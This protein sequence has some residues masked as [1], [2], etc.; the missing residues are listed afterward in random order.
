[1]Q[2]FL[3][4]VLFFV[5]LFAA[6][7]FAQTA[8][9]YRPIAPIV[10]SAPRNS[11]K[12][13]GSEQGI[14]Q[15]GGAGTTVPQAA[16]PSA[17]PQGGPLCGK[18]VNE[19]GYKIYGSISTPIAGERQGVKARHQASLRLDPGEKLDVCSEGPFYDGQRL[20]LT[21]RSLFPIFSCKTQIGGRTITIRSEPR[22]QG[23]VKFYAD[24]Y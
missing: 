20:E 7:S 1:M 19:S 8:P 23:G 12:A 6:P 24:C 21:L 2:G 9:G 11:D 16:A 4:S 13:Q 10:P 17:L 18:I 5:V 15:S 22:P 3:L 14:G